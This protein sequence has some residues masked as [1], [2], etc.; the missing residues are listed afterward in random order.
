MIAARI[1]PE[2]PGEGSLVWNAWESVVRRDPSR[3]ERYDR[4]LFPKVFVIK[5]AAVLF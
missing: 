3:R 4:G 2:G 5:I 1:V